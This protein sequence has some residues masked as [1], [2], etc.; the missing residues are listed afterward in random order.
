VIVDAQVHVWAPDS[1]DR[2][3]PLG[4]LHLAHRPYPVTA[5][6]VLEGMDSL[7]IDRVILVPPSW[8]GDRNDVACAAAQ[9]HPDR[10]AVMGRIPLET[11]NPGLLTGW[12]GQP[13]MLGLRFTLHAP[14]QQ[15]WLY[16]GT[17]DW[18][19]DA[20]ERAGLPI[21]VFAP[22][23]TPRIAL[24][25]EQHP[26]LRLVIDHLALWEGKDELAFSCFDDLIA[27]ARLPNVAVKA[28]ALP[29]SS[30]E[31]YPFPALHPY[32]RRTFDAFGPHRM[33]W[34]SDWTRLPCTWQQALTIFTEELSWLTG[35][36]RELVMGRAICEWLGWPD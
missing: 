5:E 13:G 14:H 29:F 34:G 2:P 36:D 28:S 12:R 26:G 30:T 33:F 27:L 24:V 25:A 16:D 20:A 32:I 31:P 35:E 7:G 15:T 3:W 22:G 6:M 23:L 1:P 9:Q 19:W 11:P 8:E 17:V 18:V 10:F 4:R 21:M